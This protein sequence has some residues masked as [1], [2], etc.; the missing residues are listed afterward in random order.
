LSIAVLGVI[1]I[2]V[3]LLRVEALLFERHVAAVM[4]GLSSL[5]IGLSSESDA[6]AEVP[7]L[8]VDQ[9][10]TDESICSKAE[11]CLALQL[12]TPRIS[13]W[14]L[15]HLARTGHLTMYSGTHFLGFRI[16]DFEA[17]VSVRSGVVSHLNYRLMLSTPEPAYPGVLV[18]GVS[19]TNGFR[20]LRGDYLADESPDYMVSFARQFPDLSVGVAFTR[21]A[22]ADFLQHAFDLRL[23]CVSTIMG[24]RNVNQLLPAAVRDGLRIEQAVTQRMPGPHPCPDRILPRRVRDSDDILLVQVRSVR[25]APMDDG[26]KIRVADFHLLQVLK[27]EQRVPLQ[28]VEIPSNMRWRGFEMRKSAGD[29]FTP[30]RQLLIFPAPNSLVSFPCDAVEATSS[31]LQ[32]IHNSLLQQTPTESRSNAIR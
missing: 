27:G 17:T 2:P 31:A 12:T 25:D 18:I 11:R 7:G 19:S 1:A 15:Q 23:R 24:C 20:R 9:S 6:I 28:T 22:S 3:I 16:H 10:T 21:D 8:R 29:L 13:L 5:K 30:G 14:I 26:A 32:T 4:K